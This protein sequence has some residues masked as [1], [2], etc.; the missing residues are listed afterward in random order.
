M[1]ENVFDIKLE[2]FSIF[3]YGKELFVN[4]DLYIVVGCCYGLVGFNGKGKIIFF[5]Y[6]VN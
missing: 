2:K 1:L 4:V 5:K 3:V 6:I